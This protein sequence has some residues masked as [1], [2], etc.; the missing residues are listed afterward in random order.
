MDITIDCK[1]VESVTPVTLIGNAKMKLQLSDVS[2]VALQE[3]IS[4]IAIQY[5]AYFIVDALG[6]NWKDALQVALNESKG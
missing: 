6:I 2:D 4:D 5:G 1:A 3:L